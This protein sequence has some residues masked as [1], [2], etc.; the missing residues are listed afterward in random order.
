MARPI[1]SRLRGVTICFLRQP[2]DARR[3]VLKLFGLFDPTGCAVE[4]RK[5]VQARGHVRMVRT[6]GLL[7]DRQRARVERLGQR[8]PALGAVEL[9]EVVQ[10]PG[11][12]GMIRAEGLLPDGHR[13]RGRAF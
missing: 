12:I 10:A 4:L 6:Q 1:V 5:V 9:R 3:T 11:Y 7:L 13:E 8:V 2:P